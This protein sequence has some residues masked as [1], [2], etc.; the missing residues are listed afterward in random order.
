MYHL[1]SKGTTFLQN[2]FKNWETYTHGVKCSTPAVLL[3]KTEHRSRNKEGNGW[4]S[5]WG[6]NANLKGNKAVHRG[7]EAQGKIN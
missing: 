3:L 4:E 1:L 6:P 7:R 2:E 5:T